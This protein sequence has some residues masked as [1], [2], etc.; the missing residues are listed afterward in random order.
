MT[1]KQDRRVRRTKKLLKDALIELILEQ[2]Y[3]SITV[4]DILDR[5]D[6]G[7]STFYA[8]FNSKDD[9]LIGDAPFVHLKFDDVREVNGEIEIVPS[10]LDMFEHV[11]EQDHLFRA[12][13]GGEGIILVQRIV[14]SH[15]RTAF[16]DRFNTLADKGMPMP[17]PT[18][19]LTNFLTGGFMSLLTWWL[20]EGMPYSPE[21]MNEMFMQMAKGTAVFNKNQSTKNS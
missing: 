19:V 16:T 17:L 21:E 8:H 12:M 10:F 11:K 1:Q 3:D 18:P 9:L 13:M 2:G 7:R 14:L 20:D 5:A 6:V 15:L 4:Q